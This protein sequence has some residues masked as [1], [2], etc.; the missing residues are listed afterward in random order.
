MHTLEDWRAIIAASP[1]VDDD[2]KDWKRLLVTLLAETP[3]AQ[4]IQD[5][6]EIDSG[7]DEYYIRDKA[8]YVYCPDGY[9]RSK[10][11]NNFWERKQKV[12]ATT[13]NWNS[14]NKLLDLAE[15]LI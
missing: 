9:G 10:F 14:I 15:A 1:F 3:E 5:L 12:R 4:R 11:S 2:D 8:I 7:A 6:G 13:R